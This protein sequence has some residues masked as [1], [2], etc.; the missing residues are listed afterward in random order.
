MQVTVSETE[1]LYE[2]QLAHNLILYSILDQ[3][4]ITQN[5]YVPDLPYLASGGGCLSLWQFFQLFKCELFKAFPCFLC[6]NLQLQDQN[7]AYFPVTS[8]SRNE[9]CQ[10]STKPHDE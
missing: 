8:T 5:Y 4:Q 7:T 10:M 9:M 1:Y 2:E 6:N 3:S